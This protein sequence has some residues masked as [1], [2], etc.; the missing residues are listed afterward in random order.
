M[1]ELEV[2]DER[3]GEVDRLRAVDLE[4]LSVRARLA[5]SLPSANSRTHHVPQRLAWHHVASHELDD[6]VDRDLPSISALSSH[7][8]DEGTHLLT[9]HRKDEATGQDVDEPNHERDNERPHRHLRLPSL[10]SSSAPLPHTLKN[11]LTATVDR[12]SVV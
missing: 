10:H 5:S 1:P 9:R 8:R 11:E 12:K 7:V 3:V 6:E 4:E 2:L